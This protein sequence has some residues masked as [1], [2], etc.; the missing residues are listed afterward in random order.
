MRHS[1]RVGGGPAAALPDPQARGVPPI[2]GQTESREGPRPREWAC[3]D[4]DPAGEMR[5][6]GLLSSGCVSEL[7]F[8]W[9]EVCVCVRKR[10][11]PKTQGFP[12]GVVGK[13]EEH[14]TCNS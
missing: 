2:P 10:C 3:L 11:F 4:S 8:R 9:G 14:R 1:E 13:K 6:A 5:R 12:L 7:P